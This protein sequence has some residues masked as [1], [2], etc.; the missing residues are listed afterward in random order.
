MPRRIADRIRGV[1]EGIMGS[2]PPGVITRGIVSLGRK[3]Q[4]IDK[5]FTVDTVHRALKSGR[6]KLTGRRSPSKRAR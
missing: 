5:R 1:H 3:A 4:E 2:S 6:D